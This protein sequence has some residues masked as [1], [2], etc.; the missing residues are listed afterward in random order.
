MAGWMRRGEFKEDYDP[1]YYIYTVKSGDTLYGISKQFDTSFEAVFTANPGINPIMLDE[2]QQIVVPCGTDIVRTDTDYSHG[3]MVH[4]IAALKKRYPFLES[5]SAGKSVMGRELCYLRLGRGKNEVFINGCHHADEWITS[6]LLMKFTENFLKAYTLGNRIGS[7]S[8]EEIWEKASMYIMPMVNPDGV[9]LV[10]NGITQA[11]L[12]YNSIAAL[13]KGVRLFDWSANA[14][15]VDLN[16]NYDAYWGM[17]KNREKVYGIFGPGAKRFSGEGPQSEAETRTVVSFVRSR[18]F[19][20]ALSYHAGSGRILCEHRRFQSSRTQEVGEM[21]TKVSGYSISA[22]GSFIPN[23]GFKE[24]FAKEFNRPAL[25][26]EVSSNSL[27]QFER[28][29]N[30]NIEILTLAFVL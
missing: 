7:L 17:S 12:Y 30:E 21:F 28:I 27:H 14:R 23:S 25:T 29:Y 19:R 1:G 3:I 24:W 16:H 9:E 22:P 18:N 4:D 8:P 15:G 5:G 26:I 6:L 20:L 10:V 13:N 11:N 2:G